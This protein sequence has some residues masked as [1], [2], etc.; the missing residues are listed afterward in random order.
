MLDLTPVFRPAAPQTLCALGR[1]NV[2]E[3]QTPQDILDYLESK[4]AK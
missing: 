2:A 1:L 3:A 4:I